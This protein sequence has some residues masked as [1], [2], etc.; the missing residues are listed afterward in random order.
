MDNFDDTL[1]S[2]D[3]FDD[4]WDIFNDNKE[5]ESNNA[6]N[7]PEPAALADKSELLTYIKA[8]QNKNTVR[9]TQSDA[10][11]FIE[12][13]KEYPR[14]ET[15]PVQTLEPEILDNYIGQYLLSVKRKDGTDYE[16][17]TLT[18]IHRSIDRYLKEL[19]YGHSLVT[20]TAFETSKKVL[21]SR[22]KAL[23]KDGHGNRELK[24]DPL[25]PE[26]EDILWKNGQMGSHE[27][28][29]LQRALWFL[30]TKLMGKS[31]LT[32]KSNI[33]FCLYIV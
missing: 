15:R 9:K 33:R 1:V 29:A 30:T 16:P 25:T 17:D 5:N 18:S 4:S 28:G 3:L 31:V 14:S 10:S 7:V 24:A 27:P 19:G 26:D 2:F 8:Q 20:D 32:I 6:K 11:R 22:R 23:K 12:W 21:E 13:L